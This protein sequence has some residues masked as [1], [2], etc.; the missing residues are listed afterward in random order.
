MTRDDILEL[1]KQYKNHTHDKYGIDALGIFG[2]VA[3]DEIKETSDVDI[4]IKT[5]TPDMFMLVHIKEDLQ[6]LFHK[7]IDIVRIREKM[8]PYLKKK[9]EKEAI[10]V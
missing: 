7:N 6:E 4:C 5:K 9:I 3:R 10:Y 1:L 2:S 8:N